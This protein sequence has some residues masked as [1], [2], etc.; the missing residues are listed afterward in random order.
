MTV[1]ELVKSLSDCDKDV[2]DYEVRIIC[3]IQ[4]NENVRLSSKLT[5]IN[6]QDNVDVSAKILWLK[7]RL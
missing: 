4:L 7:V 1:R 3:A 6:V 5:K 2:L